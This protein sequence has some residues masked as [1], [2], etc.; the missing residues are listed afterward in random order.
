MKTLEE[1]RSDLAM[2]L[3]ELG[4]EREKIRAEMREICR[5]IDARDGRGKR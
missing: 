2:K 3:Q 5:A 1:K 4:K